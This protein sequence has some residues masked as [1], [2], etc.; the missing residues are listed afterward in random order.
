MCDDH[1][2]THPEHVQPFL[3]WIN[4]A[5]VYQLQPATDEDHLGA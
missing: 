1:S 2:D 4:L 5:L 3:I